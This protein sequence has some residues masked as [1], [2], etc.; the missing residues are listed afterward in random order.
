MEERDLKVKFMHPKGPGRL[1][2]SFYWPLTEDICFI[3][4]NDILCSISAPVPSSKSGRKYRL[5]PLDAFSI[6]T[7]LKRVL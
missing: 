5:N 4:E 1:E 2:N 7:A 3:P 6:N